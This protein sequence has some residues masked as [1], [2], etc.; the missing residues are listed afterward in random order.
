M[1]RLS[2]QTITLAAVAAILGFALCD[3]FFRPVGGG[4]DVLG[5]PLGRDFLPMWAA[6]QLAFERGAAMLTDIPAF[7]AALGERFGSA[8]IFGVWS[9]PPTAILLFMP[10]SLPSYWA[11]LT[12]WTV[13]GSAA[14]LGSA[15]ALCRR[16]HL[17]PALLLLVVSPAMWLNVETGQ[18]GALTA[19]LL[20]GGLALLERRP[21]WAGVLFGLMTFKPHIGVALAVALMAF[22]AWRAMAA[23]V[24]TAAALA[25]A[26]TMLF[27]FEAW[28]GYVEV[29]VPYTARILAASYGGQKLLLV[30]LT[31]AL[32]QAGLSL[33]AA[34][35]IQSVIAIP[36]LAALWAA[37]RRTI[38]PL[39]RLALIAAAT[40]LV[41][42]YI[43]TYDLVGL[44]AALALRV[45]GDA[46]RCP[47][48]ILAIGYLSP[49]LSMLCEIFGG[50][51]I[52]PG[53]LGLVFV[54]LSWEALRPERHDPTPAPALHEAAVSGG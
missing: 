30:S 53:L 1:N 52:A 46:G 33:N 18:N 26:A 2:R 17:R 3:W 44:G 51:A 11:S 35:V 7:A 29:S 15:A 54:G 28:R 10:F 40:P 48:W 50:V 39:R 41:S 24:A 38:D 45:V 20:M 16:E 49:A 21:G 5:Y 27:G 14:S 22:R 13:A 43:W 25:S 34:L 8:H 32:T 37:A 4:F 47:R 12:L 9:Y 31:S 36:V 6:P 42:P 23:A 19:A